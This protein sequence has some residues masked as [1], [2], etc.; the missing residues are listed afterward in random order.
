MIALIITLIFSA[1]FSG[2]EIAFVASNKM[3]AQ[4]NQQKSSITQKC[5]ARFYQQ[6]NNFI[7]TMLVGNNIA[8][9]IYGILFAQIT[10]Q[11]LTRYDIVQQP[12]IK[13]LVDTIVSTIIVLFTAEFLPKNI[14]K[15]N[16]HKFLNALAIPA[17]ITY[18]ILYPITKITTSIAQTIIKYTTKQTT[19]NKQQTVFTKNDLDNLIQ[20]TIITEINDTSQNAT[21]NTTPNDPNSQLSTKLIKNTLQLHDK[22]GRDCMIPRNEINALPQ[23]A[24]IQQLKQKFIETG[25]SKIIIYQDDIDHIIG[26]IHAAQLFNMNSEQVEEEPL[27]SPPPN[28]EGTPSGDETDELKSEQVEGLKSRQVDESSNNQSLPQWGE[29]GGGSQDGRLE[30]APFQLINIPIVPETIPLHKLMKTLMQQ[31]KTIAAVIDEFGGT[32]GIVT[33]EDIIEEILGDIQDEHDNEQYLA[34][35]I[36]PNSYIIS[37][38][39]EIHKINTLLNIQLP[40]SEEYNTLAGLI[41]YHHQD[42]PKINETIQIN[43][44]QC[45][46]IKKT[47]TKIQLVELQVTTT[48]TDNHNHK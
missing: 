35:Q 26:Y 47:N 17:Y 42:F 11:I 27:P 24:T 39:L 16:P 8:L 23:N 3:L 33:L 37:A 9:V 13:L 31:K 48:N 40:E 7:T 6:P 36:S 38:R 14:F 21:Q 45:K 19:N 34:K 44:F 29:V 30:G 15:N 1:F 25:N 20:N 22:K 2:M 46:V 32:A 43:N 18:V 10:H 5:L 4:I 28:G 12:A 41:L